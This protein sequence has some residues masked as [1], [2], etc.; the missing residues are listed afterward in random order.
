MKGEAEEIYPKVEEALKVL[1]KF[2][3]TY[4]Q[5]RQN[6]PV[7]F[8]KVAKKLNTSNEIVLWEFKNE[9]A[10]SRFDSFV[11]RVEEVHYWFCWE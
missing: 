7:Y 10:F 9:L 11:Q 8:E 4:E 3:N 2:K 5:H 6:L 1:H